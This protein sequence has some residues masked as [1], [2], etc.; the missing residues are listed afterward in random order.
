MTHFG[1]AFTISD[2]STFH[3]SDLETSS[4]GRGVQ[5]WYS[6]ANFNVYNSHSTHLYANSHH[7]RDVTVS[8]CEFEDLGQDH[9]L[10]HSPWSEYQRYKNECMQISFSSY[11]FR[12]IN[13]L[14]I[15]QWK[16]R[17]RSTRVNTELTPFDWK[18]PSAYN[19]AFSEFSLQNYRRRC[20]FQYGTSL[21]QVYDSVSLDIFRC[22][23]KMAHSPFLAIF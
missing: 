19:G 17:S 23:Q 13:I 7:F 9:R 14:N 21:Y 10:Q 15:F 12:N 22:L 6:M 16:F 8:R 2:V 1:Q 20:P 3:I 5:C 11:P 4:R 18:C